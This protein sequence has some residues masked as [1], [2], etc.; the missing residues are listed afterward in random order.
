MEENVIQIRGKITVNVS[1]NVKNIVYMKKNY[2]WN[3][4]TCSCKNGRYLTSIIDNSVIK[5]E[6]IDTEVTK[7]VKTV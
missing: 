7:T 2:I 5:C 3:H 1:A 6:I 4:A